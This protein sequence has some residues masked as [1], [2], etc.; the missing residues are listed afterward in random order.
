M[1]AQPC[2][3]VMFPFPKETTLYQC[4]SRLSDR[5]VVRVAMSAIILSVSL[6]SLF[7]CKRKSEEAAAAPPKPKPRPAIAEI[8]LK[9]YKP[10]EAGA[11]MIVMYHRFETGLPSSDAKLNRNPKDFRKDLETLHK[12]GYRPVTVSEFIENR[13][14]VPIGKTPVILTFDDS[15]PSQFRIVTGKDGQAHIDPECAVGI[16]EVFHKEHPDWALK[17]TFFVLPETNRP[18]KSTP[19][20]FGDPA[21]APDKLD[22]LISK[23]FEVQNHSS[24]HPRGGFSR[25]SAS[26]IQEEIGY[27]WRNIKQINAKAAMDVLALPE[28]KLPRKSDI[29]TIKSGKGGGAEYTLKA[30]VKAAWRPVASPVSFIGKRTAVFQIAPYDPYALERVA[31]APDKKGQQTFE[32]WM[33]WFDQNPDQR[34]VSDGNGEV[35]A[36]PA[37]RKSLVDASAVTKQGKILQLYKIGGGIGSGGLNVEGSAS[38]SSAGS[39][40]SAGSGLG[41]E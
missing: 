20:P 17:G 9:A 12:K 5:L 31:P 19:A 7:G 13:M 41:V 21:S 11:V 15:S 39:A 32:Y 30:V 8:D 24:T 33:D 25:L 23:G 1:P 6:C 10:N 34:Y 3:V 16:M 14:D 27:A 40:G 29:Q 2:V 4:L 35:V 22:Y 36:V 26:E 37:G 28:G 38:T 18:G